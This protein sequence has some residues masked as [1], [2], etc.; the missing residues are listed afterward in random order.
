MQLDLVKSRAES[1]SNQGNPRIP[2]RPPP[3]LLH[4]LVPVAVSSHEQ[5]DDDTKGASLNGSS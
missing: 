1:I 4:L 5:L 3:T 2:P